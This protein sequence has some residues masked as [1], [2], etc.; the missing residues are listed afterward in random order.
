MNCPL[1]LRGPLWSSFSPSSPTRGEKTMGQGGVSVQ[2]LH[3]PDHALG[4]ASPEFPAPMVLS[5]FP[6]PGLLLLGSDYVTEAQTSRPKRSLLCGCVNGAWMLVLDC[7]HTCV[8]G[9]CGA[10]QM[11]GWIVKGQAMGW[12]PR[13]GFPHM[14]H[15]SAKP[16]EV[17]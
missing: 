12:G 1:H 9:F 6:G 5:L 15:S 16:Q 2:S 4:S 11:Q 17:Q 10:G 3:F 13:T 8:R 7:P 14:P